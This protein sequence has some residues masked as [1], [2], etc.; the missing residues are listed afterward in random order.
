MAVCRLY[1]FD[2]RAFHDLLLAE[3]RLA[4]NLLGAMAELLDL[5][6]PR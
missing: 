4:V 3:P 5:T 2:T 1:R 6:N